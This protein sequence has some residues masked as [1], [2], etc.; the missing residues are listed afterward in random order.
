V[1]MSSAAAAHG[2]A[3]ASARENAILRI[4]RGP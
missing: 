3:A 1:P 2:A 4:L